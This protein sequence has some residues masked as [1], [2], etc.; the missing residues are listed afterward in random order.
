MDEYR[1]KKNRWPRGWHW[2]LGLAGLAL[3]AWQLVTLL[4]VLQ[5]HTAHAQTISRSAGWSGQPVG[6]MAQTLSSDGNA[7]LS[8]SPQ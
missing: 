3:L 6:T 8:S 7:G 4:E 1:L 2:L 5:A